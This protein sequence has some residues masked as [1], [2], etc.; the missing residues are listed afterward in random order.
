MVGWVLAAGAVILSVAL[1]YFWTEIAQWLNNTA[2]NAVERKF[3]IDARKTMQR[4]VCTVTKIMNKIDNVARV[5]FR[6]DEHY[7]KQID[8]HASRPEYEINEEVLQELDIK[9]ELINE[10]TYNG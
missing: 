9:K 10:F 5:Y 7:L 3:G 4:A 6:M 1:K 8:L 2:A